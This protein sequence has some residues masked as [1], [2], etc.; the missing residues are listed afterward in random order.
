MTTH[1]STTEEQYRR[2]PTD[3]LVIGA[4]VG[5]LWALI[6]LVGRIFSWENE[7]FIAALGGKKYVLVTSLIFPAI[8]WLTGLWQKAAISR[9]HGAHYKLRVKAI[10]AVMAML[11]GVILCCKTIY[12]EDFGEVKEEIIWISVAAVVFLLAGWILGAA[13]VAWR[14]DKYF[15]VE[16]SVIATITLFTS[17]IA[18]VF[19]AGT[20]D[21]M[22][23]FEF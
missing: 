10:T 9:Y 8:G 1:D 17:T 6:I 23:F 13:S 12:F 7:E 16:M 20:I 2:A 4:I 21:M 19:V 5:V 3:G 15:R 22:F 14:G 18:W 11:C